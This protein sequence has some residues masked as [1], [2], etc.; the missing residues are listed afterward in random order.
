MQG[1]LYCKAIPADD[2]LDWWRDWA[3]SPN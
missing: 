1:F 2:V 3:G